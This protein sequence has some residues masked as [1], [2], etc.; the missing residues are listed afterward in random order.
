MPLELS[1]LHSLR[2]GPALASV[3]VGDIPEIVAQDFG[4]EFRSVNLSRSTYEEIVRKH[5][6]FSDYDFLQIPYILRHGLWL[7]ERDEIHCRL[8]LSA[9]PNSDQRYKIVVN[10]AKYGPDLWVKSFHKTRPR[11]TRALLRRGRIIRNF[12]E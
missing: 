2:L 6:D 1:R 8:A 5:P 4:T 12:K 10:K 3:P 7:A 11:A 9:I